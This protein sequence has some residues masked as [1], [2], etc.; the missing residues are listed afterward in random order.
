MLCKSL[1]TL[2]CTQPASCGKPIAKAQMIRRRRSSR[3]ID[4]TLKRS[5]VTEEKPTLL[6]VQPEQKPAMHTICKYCNNHPSI[7]DH[8]PK[9]K[10]QD[11]SRRNDKSELNKCV[12]VQLNKPCEY[13]TCC[14]GHSV[15][16]DCSP[17]SPNEIHIIE[18]RSRSGKKLKERN[19]KNWDILNLN[20]P[21]HLV[22]G[23]VEISNDNDSVMTRSMLKRKARW[24]KQG[25]RN[26]RP[27]THAEKKASTKNNLECSI[28]QPIVDLNS[29]ANCKRQRKS[30]KIEKSEACLSGSPEA[31]S[32]AGKVYDTGNV[33]EE[34]EREYMCYSLQNVKAKD[35]EGQSEIRTITFEEWQKEASNKWAAYTSSECECNHWQNGMVCSNTT[36]SIPKIGTNCV[37]D[38]HN[39][40]SYM[41]YNK[42][43]SSTVA[44]KE[45]GVKYSCDTSES[46]IGFTVP[47]I[48][49]EWS[50]PKNVRYRE[51]S[52][53]PH[54]NDC[55]QTLELLNIGGT[56]VLGEFIPF[57]LL[58]APRL[59]S[60]GQWINT[61]IYGK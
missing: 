41:P 17:S 2:Q 7:S 22:G 38:R 50:E 18:T 44:K 46:T 36:D 12:H 60:L 11:R 8:A 51:I 59:K 20:S 28:V 26:D 30:P 39:I 52:G 25:G 3:L 10:K 29:S 14:T 5:N 56:N 9:A 23:N 19:V 49:S 31:I 24:M 27:I 47:S 61:M 32:N 34:K 16:V 15:T 37:Q 53:W 33:G 54:L 40:S 21:L 13:Q 6:K 4:K 57:I 35:E 1:F 55:I 43:S 58:Y 42:N 48:E 45:T